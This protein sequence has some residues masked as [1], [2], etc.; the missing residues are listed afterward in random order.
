MIGRYGTAA[1]GGVLFYNLDNEPMLWNSTHRD[2]HPQPL[3]YD[4]LRDRTYTYGAAIK[5]ADPGAK[6]LGPVVVGV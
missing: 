5:A 3:S 2:V 1:S 4:E 6:T